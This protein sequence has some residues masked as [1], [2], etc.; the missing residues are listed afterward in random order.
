[1]NSKQILSLLTKDHKK[2]ALLLIIIM[3]ISSFMEI[4]N[5]SILIVIIN[6]LINSENTSSNFIFLNYL[7]EYFNSKSINLNYI[8]YL[9]LIIFVTKIFILIYVSLREAK[10]V[11]DIK[12]HI[13]N[14]LFNDF[15]GRDAHKILKKNSSIY[16]RNFTTEI[17]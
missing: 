12:E 7:S 17:D 9:F 6:F 11:A 13:S 15:L 1:M 3:F 4:F 2:A 16:L 8:L 10:F 5:L 14:S